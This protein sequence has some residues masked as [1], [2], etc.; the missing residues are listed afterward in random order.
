MNPSAQKQEMPES[1][2]AAV[3]LLARQVALIN[4]SDARSSNEWG[5]AVRRWQPSAAESAPASGLWDQPGQLLFGSPSNAETTT[6]YSDVSP[7]NNSPSTAPGSSLDITAPIPDGIARPNARVQGPIGSLTS[8][9]VAATDG[10][11]TGS[12]DA[13]W[14]RTLAVYR[15]ARVFRPM[16]SRHQYNPY[17]GE[18]ASALVRPAPLPQTRVQALDNVLKG[19]SP[20]YRGN[21]NL[22]QNRSADIPEA[23]NCA[24]WIIGLPPHMTTRNLLASIRGCGRVYAT[25]ISPPDP[26]KQITS[27]AVKVVFFDRASTERFMGRYGGFF[28]IAGHEGWNTRGIRITPNRIRVREYAGPR[29]HSR[30]LHVFG[31]AAVVNLA[32][33]RDF[34]SSRFDYQEDNFE[35]L[36]IDERGWATVEC[37]FG[38]FRAQSLIA[39]DALARELSNIQ[40]RFAPD[41]CAFE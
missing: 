3:L 13:D 28:P 14:D 4:F 24:L 20:N 26:S 9:M 10:R 22:E 25:S 29:E 41:P 33:L 34:F 6:F 35:E 37:A 15:Q 7:G 18:N 2:E 31:D 16:A 5:Q 40:A 21:N 30:V 23:E 19:F 17:N 27:S 36:G 8:S 11:P 32:F 12:H 1:Y 39:R 38:S